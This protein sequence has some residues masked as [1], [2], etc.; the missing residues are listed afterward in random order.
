MN[1]F[2][3][4]TKENYSTFRLKKLA[5]LG[6]TLGFGGKMLL[7]GLL[8]V[9]AVLG[10]IWGSLVLF[11]IF[12]HDLPAKKAAEKTVLP[13]TT[14]PAPAGEE[15]FPEELVAVFAA[16]IAAAESDAGGKKFRVVSFKRI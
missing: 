13:E 1:L 12:F 2:L 16:A 15:A 11:R 14:A 7:I 10:L 5:D 4:I 8:T 9:F 6:E 3:E